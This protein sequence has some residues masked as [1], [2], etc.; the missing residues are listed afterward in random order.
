ML[1]NYSKHPCSCYITNLVT[2]GQ[3][4]ILGSPSTHS[5]RGRSCASWKGIAHSASGGLGSSDF[6]S[7]A[8][9]MA[10]SSPHNVWPERQYSLW[11]QG[12]VL[13]TFS[14]FFELVDEGKVTWGFTVRI[15]LFLV[16]GSPDTA[17]EKSEMWCSYSFFVLP[18]SCVTITFLRIL[19]MEYIKIYVKIPETWGDLGWCNEWGSVVPLTLIIITHAL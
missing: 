14:N 9:A 5:W 11:T 13:K 17:C 1:Q 10:S 4:D 12:E 3:Q 16:G 2:Q 18:L 15:D 6:L 7:Q 19:T 8:P